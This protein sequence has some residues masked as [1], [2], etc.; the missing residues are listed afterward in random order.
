MIIRAVP[1]RGECRPHRIHII[2]TLRTVSQAAA[3]LS[4]G[5][6]TSRALVDEALSAIAADGTAFMR[7]YADRARADAA[8]ADAARPNGSVPS[9]LAGI[10]ISIKDLFDV[11]GEPTPAGSEILRNGPNA[12]RDAPVVA[13]LRAAGAIIIGRTHMSEF[14]FSGLGTNPHSPRLSNP[15]DA[16]RVPGGSSSGAAASVA[17]GQAVMGLGTDT[18][19]SVRIPAAFCGVTGFK[20][21]QRRVTRDGAFPL[22]ESLDS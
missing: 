17:R 9:L 10:P 16:S 7:V 18:G 1:S 12:L 13:R 20:P 2:M 8:E 3:E 14:A 5:A 4:R 11:A 6:V 15:R 22:A 19:G 21:T